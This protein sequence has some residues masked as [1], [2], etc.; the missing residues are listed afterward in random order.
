MHITNIYQLSSNCSLRTYELWETFTGFLCLYL[1]FI[2]FIFAVTWTWLILI[3]RRIVMCVVLL[4]VCFSLWFLSE[5]FLLSLKMDSLFFVYVLSS[6][7]SFYL[8]VLAC[9]IPASRSW[10]A[11]LFLGISYLLDDF[12]LL[13]L[14][15]TM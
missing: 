9:R 14:G 15:M 13:W 6:V 1:I 4:I 3:F 7:S 2:R 5:S 10:V 11:L 12:Y 8:C